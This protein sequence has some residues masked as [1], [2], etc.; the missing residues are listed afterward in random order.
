MRRS[1]AIYLPLDEL[2]AFGV[3]ESDIMEGRFNEK[4]RQLFRFQALRAR[5][6]YAKAHRLMVPSDR[7]KLLAAEIMRENYEE[8]LNKIERRNFDV[9]SKLV[10]NSKFAKA[11]LV[12]RAK[13]REKQAPAR[14]PKPKKVGRARRRL[15]GARSSERIDPARA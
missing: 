4:M 14:P 10:R 7:P 12:L 5:H 15:C 1:G 11:C 8:L 9:M 13:R 3:S 2:A 6:Y